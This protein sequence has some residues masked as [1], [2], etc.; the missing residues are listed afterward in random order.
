MTPKPRPSRA[1]TGRVRV[2][3]NY[4]TRHRTEILQYIMWYWDYFGRSPTYAEIKYAFG[5]KS[6]STVHH[7]LNG[8][9]REGSI[10]RDPEHRWMRVRMENLPE[11]CTHDWRTWD[12]LDGEIDIICVI[13]GRQTQAEFHP[14]EDDPTTWLRYIPPT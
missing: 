7:L 9:E 6:L 3:N 14:A 10:Y 1:K 13:C 2:G 12:N 5:M 11:L 4:Y 8:L